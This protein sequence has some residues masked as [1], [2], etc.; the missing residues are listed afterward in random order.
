[1]DSSW[2]T[3]PRSVCLVV[4]VVVVAAAAVR[5]ASMGKK[6][7]KTRFAGRGL[8]DLVLRPVSL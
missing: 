7:R 5:P 6:D 8:R 3:H 2:Q 4:V 1:M